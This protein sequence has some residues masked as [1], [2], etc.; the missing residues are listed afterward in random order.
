[1]RQAAVALLAVPIV[2]AVRAGATLRRSSLVRVGLAVGLAIV[3][4]IG[5]SSGGRPATTV[6][7]PT[8]PI[9][10]LTQTAF[11]TTFSTHRGLAEPVTIVFTT[12][13]DPASV[14]AA[15]TVEPAT[16]VALTWDATQTILTVAP[17][18]R[19]AAGTA[20]HGHRPGGRPR[21]SGQPS[22]RPAR[23]AFLTRDATTASVD[24]ER[25]G[26]G[27]RVSDD[28]V[29]RL[30]RAAG[31]SATSVAA[32]RLDPP[33]AGTVSRSRPGDGPIRF[34]FVPSAPLLPDVQYR[35]IV[36][37][38]RDIDGVPL[39]TISWRSG[40]P[41]SPAVVRFRPGRRTGTTSRATPPSRSASVRPWTGALRPGRSRPWSARRRS[42]ARSAGLNRT[43]S[44]SSRPTAPLPFGATVS[45]AVGG[46]RHECHRRSAGAR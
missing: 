30:V 10:P 7:T 31:R 35:L 11:T 13:M 18:Q 42:P 43:P 24:R 39:D 20:Q 2:V 5:V 17:R 29:P 36:S 22:A 38:V 19:W 9:V 34:L 46:E 45:M 28:L 40:P 25:A 1:M 26:I 41:A 37:G 23:A 44:S 14:A 15:V 8:R 16:P 3:L 32:I 33:T 6:A 12:P 27:G 21:P 4:G